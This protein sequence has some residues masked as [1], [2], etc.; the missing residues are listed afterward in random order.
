[1]VS[2]PS[3]QLPARLATQ[4]VGLLAARVVGLLAAQLVAQLK[5]RFTPCL[6]CQVGASISCSIYL[7]QDSNDQ[8]RELGI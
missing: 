1:M 8:G 4:V 2:Q 3:T 5:P 7:L 6:V